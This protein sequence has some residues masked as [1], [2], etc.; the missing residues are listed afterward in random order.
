MQLTYLQAWNIKEKA[1]ERIYG[2]PKYYY[3]LLPW[4]CEKMVATNRESVVE[5]RHSSDGHFEQLFVAYSVSIQGFAMGCWP[6]IA[7][8]STHTSGPYKGALFSAIAYDAN[9]SMFPLAFGVMSS[10][11]YED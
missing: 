1:N 11:H 9:D 3:K 7:I 6:I 10:E 5:L 4:M 8:N 2:E